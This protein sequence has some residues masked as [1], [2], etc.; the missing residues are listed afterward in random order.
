MT[1]GAFQSLETCWLAHYPRD[2]VPL[3]PKFLHGV[4]RAGDYTCFPRV[5][6]VFVGNLY[7]IYAIIGG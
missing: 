2:G 1:V 3:S 4:A 6:V 5:L 7:H